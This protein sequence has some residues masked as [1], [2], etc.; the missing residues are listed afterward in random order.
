M[1]HLSSSRHRTVPCL[2]GITS[3]FS[4]YSQFDYMLIYNVDTKEYNRLP[5]TNGKY[6]FVSIHYWADDAKMKIAEY[7]I[8]YI[9]GE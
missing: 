3:T 9:K 5:V 2:T 6:H 1:G 7:T 8:D 4:E